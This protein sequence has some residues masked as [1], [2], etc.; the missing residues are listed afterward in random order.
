M[1]TIRFDSQ[2]QLKMIAEGDQNS[3]ITTVEFNNL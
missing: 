2:N 1:I 3:F